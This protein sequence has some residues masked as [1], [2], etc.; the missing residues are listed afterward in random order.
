[1]SCN[2]NTTAG[3]DQ[4]TALSLIKNKIQIAKPAVSFIAGF[5]IHTIGGHGQKWCNGK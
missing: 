1:M 4:H 2:A 5:F 3:G